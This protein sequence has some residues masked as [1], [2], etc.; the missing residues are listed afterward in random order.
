MVKPFKFN[1]A[2]KQFFGAEVGAGSVVTEKDEARKSQITITQYENEVI[3][4]V[5]K[6]IPRGSKTSLSERGISAEVSLRLYPTGEL[7]NLVLLHPKPDRTELRI[8]MKAGVFKP[9]AGLIWFVY[10]RNEEI[11]IGA[12]DEYSM[13]EIIGGNTRPTSQQTL[14]DFSDDEFQSVLQEMKRPRTIEQTINRIKRDPRIARDALRKSGYVCEML[15]DHP[16]FTSKSNDKPYLEAHHLIPISIQP[17]FEISL[18]Q[19]ENIC[20]LNPYAHKMVHHATYA[21]IA[22]HVKKLVAPRE[23]FLKSLELSVD[24]VLKIY[25]GP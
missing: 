12:L 14:I 1:E 18:D 5:F 3:A 19:S 7:I 23:A 24:D 11:W 17:K 21:L 16:A 2:L 9:K 8:Y 10:V 6:N 22:D 13:S 4:S 20:I 25:G 15:P